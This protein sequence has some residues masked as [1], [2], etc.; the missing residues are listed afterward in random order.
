MPGR[1]AQ[2]G[3]PARTTHEWVRTRLRSAIFAGDYPPGSKLVQ[4]EI[5]EQLG[6][7]VT[8]VREAMRDLINEGLVDFDPHR[9]ATVRAI[10]I[11][12]AIEVNELR[13]V[14]EPLAVRQAAEHITAEEL[15]TLRE[16]EATMEATETHQ[17]W[18]E[19]NRDFHLAV[20]DAARSPRLAGI[21]TNLRQISSF[22]L[23]AFARVGG[24]DHAKS[25]RDHRDLIAALAAGDGDRASTIM[26]SHLAQT[27][28][29]TAGLSASAPVE[30]APAG[31]GPVEAERAG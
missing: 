2:D 25:A 24:V 5:A 27:D 23:A 18:L 13:L 26:A 15:E 21:L 10:D 31:A 7:S 4:T 3:R 16:L 12:D 20:I 19:A 14:L 30:N 6:I 1:R 11:A 29:L 17:D 22:Y 8:P 9:A 28:Q